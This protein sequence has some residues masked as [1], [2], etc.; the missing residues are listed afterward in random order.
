MEYSQLPYEV[1]GLL[2]EDDLTAI[3]I[4]CNNIRFHVDLIIRALQE[5]YANLI[6]EEYLKLRDWAEKDEREESIEQLEK[7]LLNPYY[8]EM[9]QLAPELVSR[10]PTLLEY[11][12]PPTYFFKLWNKG[13]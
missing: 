5:P 8:Q 12:D 13:N 4:M 7:W 11:F 3:T 1:L 6:K 10:P 2:L 9:L